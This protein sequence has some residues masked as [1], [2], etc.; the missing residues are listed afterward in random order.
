MRLDT[1]PQPIIIETHRY[2]KAD[3]FSPRVE[4]FITEEGI[5]GIMGRFGNT[6]EAKEAIRNG[7]ITFRNGITVAEDDIKEFVEYRHE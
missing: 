5:P 4:I 1:T 7:E 2:P 6:E 3:D